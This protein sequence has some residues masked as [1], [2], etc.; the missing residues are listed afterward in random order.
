MVMPHPD[1]L[2][3]MGR[4]ESYKPTTVA[5]PDCANARSIASVLAECS[6]IKSAVR[7]W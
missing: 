1:A 6:F 5:T 3:A 7:L 4:P 2:V